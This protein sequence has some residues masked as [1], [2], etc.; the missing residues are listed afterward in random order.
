MLGFF[1]TCKLIDLFQPEP[2]KGFFFYRFPPQKLKVGS[3]GTHF[4]LHT[5][6]PPTQ[7]LLHSLG[8]EISPLMP[9]RLFIPISSYYSPPLPHWMDGSNRS[10]WNRLSRI[11]I[12]AS[13]HPCP[14]P[15][16]PER[17]QSFFSDCG[18]DMAPVGFHAVSF[19]FSA[20]ASA[21]WM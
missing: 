4:P 3:V 6:F 13:L 8:R 7:Q 20:L 18:P 5:I 16:P 19:F 9:P 12:P 21:G 15:T 17:H 14:P 2:K 1:V 10:I 11:Q